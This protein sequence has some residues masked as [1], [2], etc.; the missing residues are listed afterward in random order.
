MASSLEYL[1]TV[2]SG[3]DIPY[4]SA[5]NLDELSTALNEEVEDVQYNIVANESIPSSVIAPPPSSKYR[6]GAVLKLPYNISQ[7][8]LPLVPPGLKV[9]NNTT[10]TTTTC[11][12]ICE[13]KESCLVFPILNDGTK[14]FLNTRNGVIT[15]SSVESFRLL[16][17]SAPECNT[18]GAAEYIPCKNLVLPNLD[19]LNRTRGKLKHILECLRN[20]NLGVVLFQH[21]T[22][23]DQNTMHVSYNTVFAEVSKI[24]LFRGVSV[25]IM[26]VT[27]HLQTG[28]TNRT[29]SVLFL[30]EGEFK[31][32]MSVWPDIFSS[33]S[34][35]VS[36]ILMMKQQ[37]YH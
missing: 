9:D 20:N 24:G 1:Q 28:A 11:S 33:Y 34:H 6:F 36:E 7:F 4:D 19:F 17:E 10:T 8:Y 29:M 30:N 16:C 23:H 14:L 2:E 18:D 35:I 32:M 37:D 31:Y 27:V 5:I 26:R 13:N 25:K 3:Y 22:L 21:F 15:I 12:L